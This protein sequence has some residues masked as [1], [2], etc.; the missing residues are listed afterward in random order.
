MRAKAYAG[1]FAG[2]IRDDVMEGALSDL[3]VDLPSLARLAI[4][5]SIVAT[6]SLTA[7]VTVEGGSYAGGFAGA[8][9]GSH[10]VNDSL[11]G[12]V[13]V[14]ASGIQDGTADMLAYAGGFTGA[15][16]LGW[17]MDLGAGDYKNTNLLNGVG[18]LL[19]GLLG[20]ED[21]SKASTLLSL[22]GLNESEILGAQMA[23][24]FMVSSAN[25]YAGGMVGRGTGPVIASSDTAH[26]GGL[27]FYKQG[28]LDATAVASRTTSLTGLDS[29]TAKAAT[30]AA[31]RACLS[32]VPW[33]RC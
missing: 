17:A 13:N 28:K 9:A 4:P 19:K 11:T 26:V 16:T 18:G 7:D 25:D 15:A 22:A 21:Q 12:A 32:P 14:T 33:R 5:Q 3:G 23:G 29:V 20:S 30:P 24:T 2:V 27:A 31:S 8:M 1:G 10:A 6:S